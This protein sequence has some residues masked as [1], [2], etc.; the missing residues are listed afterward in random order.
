[1]HSQYTAAKRQRPPGASAMPSKP[2]VSITPRGYLT[3]TYCAEISGKAQ[4][5]KPNGLSL[6]DAATVEMRAAA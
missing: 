3:S 6:L 1:M 4:I 5:P 2:L